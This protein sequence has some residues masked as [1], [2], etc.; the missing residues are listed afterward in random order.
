MRF[1][2]QHY[3]NPIYIGQSLYI[4]YMYMYSVCTRR[5]PC[6]M[7]PKYCMNGICNANCTVLYTILVHVR[8]YSATGSNFVCIC[9]HARVHVCSVCVCVCVCVCTCQPAPS[10]QS[11]H[12][13]PGPPPSPPNI[14]RTLLRIKQVPTLAVST[15]QLHNTVCAC[16]YRIIKILKFWLYILWKKFK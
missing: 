6:S 4:Q 3:N 10:I 13:S 7:P 14:A 12:C 9:V 16:I 5:M 15:Q 2:P 1:R 8:A 11:H